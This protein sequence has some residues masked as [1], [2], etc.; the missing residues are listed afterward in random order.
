MN[1]TMFRRGPDEEGYFI[2]GPVGLAMRRLSIID[3][4]GGKQPVHNE[5]RSVWLIFNGEIFNFQEL[6]VFLRGKGHTF[7]TNSDTETIVHLYEEFGSNLVQH[8]RGMFS[9][10]LWDANRQTLLLARDRV[11]IKPLFYSTTSKGE[12]VFASEIKAL[13]QHPGIGDKM[14]LQGLDA[15][16][17]YGYIPHDL[18]IFDGIHKLLPGHLMEVSPLGRTVRK[19]WDLY[20]C[21]DHDKSEK[22]FEEEFLALFSEAVRMRLVSDVPLGAFLSGGIDSSLV[23]SGMARAATGR[24]KTFTVGFDHNAASHIDERPYARMLVERY[25]C[26]HREIVVEPKVDEI[27]DEVVSAFDEPFADDSVIPTYCICQNARKHVTVA[28]T[29]LGGDELFCGYERY[30]GL[31]LSEFYDKVGS[32][33]PGRLLSR[34]VDSVPEQK[35][36]GYLVNHAKRFLAASSLPTHRRYL[37][38]VSALSREERQ[39]LFSGEV[40]RSIDFD[41]TEEGMTDL[42]NAENASTPLDRA[43]YLDIKTYLP[44]DILALTDRIGMHH[45]LELRVPF[46]DHTLMEFCATIPA[47]LKIRRFKKKHLLRKAAGRYVPGEILNHRKQGFSSPIAQWLKG[48]LRPLCDRLLSREVIERQSI[49]D[50]KFVQGSIEEHLQRKRLNDKLLFSLIMFQKWFEKIE[51]NRARKPFEREKDPRMASLGLAS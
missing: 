42:Y 37:R 35:S 18:T 26:D 31:R 1:D 6:K 30:L 29:G 7:L 44:E 47:G 3:I 50:W 16:F 20:F 23:V 43:A 15:F 21:P 24:P 19:Y 48:D 13:R 22:A 33:L 10:A 5:D 11:G 38:Y 28:L 8:L 34:L 12:I 49:F 25:Q 39:Q 46:T 41:A 51:E 14:N 40:C 36:G 2:D 17:S 27:L 9:F 32:F 4:Q 45:S